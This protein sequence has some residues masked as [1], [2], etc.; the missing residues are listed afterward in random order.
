MIDLLSTA[1]G[2]RVV[3][4]N[5]EFFAE[6]GNLI[7]V[8]PPVWREGEY[9]DQGKWMDGW[10]TRRR[11]E[12]G[13]DWCVLALGIPGRVRRVTVDT[14]HFTGN[15]PESFSLD[16]CGVGDDERLREEQWSQIIDRTVLSG[17]SLA[18]FDVNDRHR[19]THLRLNIFPDGGVARLRVEGDP[20]PGVD[21]VCPE[22]RVDLASQVVGG[23]ALDAS[24]THYSHPS[25]LLR[26]TPSRGMWDGW[27]TKRRRGPGHD[28]VSFRLG[29]PGEVDRVIVDTTHF[30]GNSPGWVSIEVSDDGDRWV[31]TAERVPVTAHTVNVISLD[32]PTHAGYVRLS[33][34]PDGGVARLRV[35]GRPDRYAAGLLRVEYLNSLFDPEANRFFQTACA[36]RRWV[37]TMM[38]ARPLGDVEDLLSAASTAFDELGEDDW[39]EAFEGH[40]RIG[41]RGD[42]VATREQ[43]GVAGSSESVLRD[44]AEVNMAYE[45]RF[46][47]TY[48]VYAT[49]KTAM[50]M[51]EIARTRLGNTREAEMT[52]AAGE[53]RRITETRLRQM[54][55][56]E[57]R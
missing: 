57:M 12:P 35:M 39:L 32:S 31:G 22:G 10:E 28:W 44:L 42:L 37:E 6:S 53:Q 11:R 47:F 4:S 34:H 1:V 41:E 8:E 36:S 14:S 51:L 23:V 17:D 49:G 55:C 20:L 5:D 30:K 9:T 29:L 33:I 27:E 13:H 50:E 43:S 25:N 24:D 52:N 38:R 15:Y 18:T 26:P 40:P 16:G 19:V 2:G 21:Y 48:I 3:S 56:Q 7:K 54:T 46:G 45:E